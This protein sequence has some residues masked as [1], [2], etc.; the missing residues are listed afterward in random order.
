MKTQKQAYIYAILSVLLWSTAASAFKIT[1]RYLTI[2]QLL[3]FS[4]LTAAMAS[5]IILLFQGK[6]RLLTSFIPPVNSKQCG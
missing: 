3:F 5:F 6:L 1:L 4:S 2:I